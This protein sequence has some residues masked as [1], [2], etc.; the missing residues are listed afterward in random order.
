MRGTYDVVVVGSGFGGA[1]AACRL[2]QAGRSVCILERG[3]KWNKGDFPR[4]P[5]EISKSFWRKGKSFG[6]LEYKAFKRID[7]IQGCG[8]GGGSLHYFNVHL[9]TPEAIFS[10][11]MWPPELR[12][13][14]LNPY[15]DL[16][17]EMLESAPLTPPS[18]R[19]LPKRTEAFLAA[20]AAAGRKPELVPIGVY[21]GA[22]RVNPYSG[23]PQTA[24]DYS[25]DCMLGCDLHAK[26]TLDLNYISVAERN[27]AEVLP[28]HQA[29]KIE[30]LGDQGYRVHFERFDPGDPSRS[31]FSAVIA[32]KVILAAGTLGTNELL[33]RCRDLHRTLPNISPMLG[34]GFSGNGDFLLAGTVDADREIDPGRGPSI[35]IGADFSTRN[36]KIFVEDLGF[37][38]PFMWLLEGVIPTSHRFTNLFKAA[39]TYLLDSIGLGSGYIDLEVNRLFRGGATTRFLPYLGMGTDA[40][41][42]RLNLKGGLIN[43]EWSHRKS[44]RMFR[45]LEDSLRALSRGVRGKYVTSILWRWPLRKLLTAHPLGGCRMGE[46][47]TNSVVDHRGMVWDYPNLYV[48]D[49]SMIP[50]A[51]S[52]NPSL[53]ISALAERTAFWITYGREMQMGDHD[54]PKNS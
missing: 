10:Q 33:L 49:G 30:P 20:A 38:N 51:L 45:E 36:N 2:T 46:S 16:A 47:K 40:A 34:T 12:R 23:K 32:R 15:Y 3:R 44:K 22:D 37:P 13:A 11:G 8:V 43:I 19:G 24:C 53:T 29:D 41:D 39:R 18:G 31:E 17:E 5:A 21:T 7:V 4:S 52:V 14:T 28:L 48:T 54:T 35:T 9:R 26:N 42:G 6:F 50:S 25:G 27:G 1:I